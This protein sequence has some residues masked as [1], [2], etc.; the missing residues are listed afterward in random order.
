MPAYINEIPSNL[1]LWETPTQK[2]VIENS[3]IDII[4]PQ[5]GFEARSNGTLK[6]T[7]PGNDSFV[8]LFKSDIYLK[9]KLV[10]VGKIG[11]TDVNTKWSK[12]K[13]SKL[14]VVNNIAHS[15][16][17]S[18]KVRVANQDITISDDCYG[19]K[20]YLQILLNSTEE[21]Q[22]TYY[23]V[24]GWIKDK[25]GKMNEMVSD[26]AETCENPA[27]IERRKLFTDEDGIAEVFLKPHVGI[28]FLDKSIIPYTDIEFELTRH[29]NNDFYMCHNAASH[30]F[31]IEILEAKY[32]VQRYKCQ[33]NYVSDVE[34]MIIEHPLTYRIKDS[35]VN[36]FSIPQGLSNYSNDNLFYS[37]SVPERIIFLF[38]PTTAYNGNAKENPFDFRHFE[39]ES[40]KLM[41]NGQLYPT[42]EILTNFKT[43]PFLFI[44]AY[45][46]FMKSIGSDYNSHTTSITTEEYH[47][48]FYITSYLMAPDQESGSDL[49]SITNS[50]SQ[51]R[52]DIRFG[53]PLPEPVQMLV[54]FESETTMMLNVKREALVMH[55]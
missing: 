12:I 11:E 32:W 9:L 14:S 13:V 35:F 49:S 33:K 7:I 47:N 27:V 1:N 34:K 48:G 8:N 21:S 28:C 6:F 53:T 51:I 25:A 24:N 30:L 4:N 45:N 41:K 19:Y 52:V 3:Y 23:K 54:Y 10:G 2:T 44:P 16:F 37:G 38:I 18:I 36:N 43:T 26:T 5:S 22:K 55:K 31:D 15:L 50:P 17:K 42:P 40:I 39:I 46:R 20:A 29:D